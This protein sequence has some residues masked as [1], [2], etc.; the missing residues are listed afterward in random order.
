MSFNNSEIAVCI[1]F[2]GLST[3]NMQ[4]FIIRLNRWISHGVVPFINA[5]SL[6]PPHYK[7]KKLFTNMNPKVIPD[8]TALN[9]RLTNVIEVFI[10]ILT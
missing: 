3:N 2:Q 6:L 5:S 1:S 9:K 8:F 4:R 10:I 7:P